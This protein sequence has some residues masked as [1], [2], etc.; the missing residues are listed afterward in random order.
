[1]TLIDRRGFIKAAGIGTLSLCL[2]G[3]SNSERTGN[4]SPVE[5]PNVLF[6]CVDDLRTELGCYGKELIHSPNLDRLAS[7]GCL[8]SNH[9]VSVPTCGASRC[10]LLTGKLPASRNDISNEAIRTKMAGKPETEVPESFIHHLRRNG[11]YTVGIGKISHYADGRLYGYNEQP[12]AELEMPHSWDEM[13]FDPGKWLTGWNAFFAYADGSNRQSRKKKAKPYESADVMDDGYPDGL[14]TD[15]A[16]EKL[17]KLSLKDQPFFLGVG[18]FKPH[19]PF[20]AP[21]KYWDLYDEDAIPVTP[22]NFIPEGVN[23]ASLHG[24]GEFNQYLLGEEKASLK[25]SVSDSYARKIK[26][27]YWACVS[28]IDAQIGILLEELNRLGLERNTIVVVWGDH[29]WHLGDHLVWGKHTNF[30]RALKSTLIVKTPDMQ[31]KGIIREQV[32]STLDIY[33]TLIELCGLDMPHPTDGRSCT[34]LLKKTEDSR[35][36]NVAYSYYRNGISM[37]TERYRLTRYFR[38]EE[39]VV[40]LYDHQTDSHENLNIAA[41]FPE[42]VNRLMP[43]L[44]KGD[45]GLY[46]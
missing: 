12:A 6:I 28:Y 26:H 1:M 15:L 45:T 9:F 23:P 17:Q 46:R 32:I 14:T 39:P 10:G 27:A 29:G 42:V 19:L 36:N 31:N 44:E 13:V 21:K 35:W 20:N 34:E 3:C 30:E 11:Y 37:R 25:E 38:K 5:R 7:E 22:S 2:K 16:L 4:G 8:F 24:S 40:E 18:Y 43:L 41:D 33:P